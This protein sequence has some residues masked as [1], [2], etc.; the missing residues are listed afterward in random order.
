MKETLVKIKEMGQ[1]NYF[2]KI[3]LSI[4]ENGKWENF[5]GKAFY[6]IT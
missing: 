5:M 3:N 1:E 4:G 6:I 2:I